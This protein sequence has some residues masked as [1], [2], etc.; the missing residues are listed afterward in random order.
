MKYLVRQSNHIKSDLE[1]N[2]SSWNYGQEGLE[3]SLDELNTHIENM[4]DEDTFFISGFE[5][6]KEEAERSE[7][8]EL[9]NNYVVLIDKETTG[10]CINY[11]KST[12]L[13]EAIKEVRNKSFEMNLSTH[14]SED[15]SGANLVWSCPDNEIHII[16]I[17]E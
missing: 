13:V 9:Y 12:S 16:E 11:L 17:N 2:W 7:F 14:D 10:L 3:I 6:T 1:R 5:L 15:C 8:G 4:S